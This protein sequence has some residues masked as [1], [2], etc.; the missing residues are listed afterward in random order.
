MPRFC[1]K[2]CAQPLE[3]MAPRAQPRMLFPQQT[4]VGLLNFAHEC[5]SLSW[6][7]WLFF[8][9]PPQLGADVVVVVV[10]FVI[11]GPRSITICLF[12][13]FLTFLEGDYHYTTIFWTPSLRT[14]PPL[15]SAL[16]IL[17][18]SKSS[19]RN[20]NQAV[21]VQIEPQGSKSSP[22]GPNQAPGGPNQALGHKT[23]LQGCRPIK[24]TILDGSKSSPGIQI[25]PWRSKSSPRGPNQALE[26]QIKPLEVQIKPW[27]TKR[28]F[29]AAGR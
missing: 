5:V 2:A 21:E 9:P 10:V 16:T 1:I 24:N 23:G 25:K 14:P 20:P 27:V 3:L 18:G 15:P 4:V 12:F 8:D 11:I 26:V 13:P 6:P 28:V 7:V 17:D 29:K 19:P 22:G